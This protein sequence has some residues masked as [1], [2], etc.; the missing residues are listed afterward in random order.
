LIAVKHPSLVGNRASSPVAT[1]QATEAEQLEVLKEQVRAD[2]GDPFNG[3]IGIST[4]DIEAKKRTVPG[5]K[6]AFDAVQTESVE[7]GYKQGARHEVVKAEPPAEIKS[8]AHLL[9]THIAQ[10][11]VPRANAGFYTLKIG[12]KSYEYPFAKFNEMSNAAVEFGL[13]R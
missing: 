11:G 5:Y 7:D 1:P 8:F 4:L 10:N 6:Q 2:I 13:V 12:D 9:N 3:I